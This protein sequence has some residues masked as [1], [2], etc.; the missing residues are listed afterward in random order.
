MLH[1]LCL[2]SCSLGFLWVS[3]ANY[4][5]GII[6]SSACSLKVVLWL[7]EQD[8]FSSYIHLFNRSRVCACIS[9]GA[10]LESWA[11]CENLPTA[12]CVCP[13]SGGAFCWGQW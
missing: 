12:G 13:S 7:S 6:V 11:K 10:G 2:A 4:K 8:F 1:S 3:T 9:R 5:G